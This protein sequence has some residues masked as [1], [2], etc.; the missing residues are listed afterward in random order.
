MLVI[1]VVQTVVVL[2]V[3]FADGVWLAIHLTLLRFRYSWFC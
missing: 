1:R 3:V 2:A